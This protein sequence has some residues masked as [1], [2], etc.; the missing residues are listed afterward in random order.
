MLSDVCDVQKKRALIIFPTEKSVLKSEFIQLFRNITS[1]SE[2]KQG[3]EM[4]KLV[5]GSFMASLNAVESVIL[6][7]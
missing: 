2:Q 6:V 5:S 3:L 1:G 4:N 7:Y